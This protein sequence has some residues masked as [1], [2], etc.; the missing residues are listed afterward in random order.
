MTNFSKPQRQSPVGIIVMFADT[1]QKFARAFWPIILISVFRSDTFDK[2][3]VVLSILGFL[4]ISAIVAYLKYLN[5]TFHIDDENNEFVI[6]DGIFNK[7]RTTISLDKIQQVNINQSLIQR[8]IN[9][10]ELNVD[11]AGSTNKEGQIKAVSHEL[12]LALKAQLLENDAKLENANPYAETVADHAEPFIK[13][14][15]LSLLKIGFTSNYLRSFGLIL[16]FFVTIYENFRKLAESETIDPTTIDSYI[17]KETLVKFSLYLVILVISGILII[18]LIRTVVKYFNFEMTKKSG[19]LI[20][21]YGLLNTKSTILRPNRV[22]IAAITRNFFQKK[23]D[24]SSIKIKQAGSG[25][26][27]QKNSVIEIPGCNTAEQNA[28]MDLLYKTIPEKGAMLT[29]NIRKLLF[30]IFL[31]IVLPLGV[32]L[33]AMQKDQQIFQL[34]WIASAYIVIV[35]IILYFSFKNYRLYV[36]D[37]FIIKQS[38]A[39]DITTE[40]IEATKI[41]AISTS[42]LFWHKKLDIGSLVLY[43]AGGKLSFQ[44]GNFTKIKNHVNTW[45][46]EIETSNSNWM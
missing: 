27:K 26:S 1:V 30:S 14:S 39:W 25:D 42:Q 41:Q 45:L 28:I 10:H 32:F 34:I 44:L 35:S 4:V 24:V 37:A 22:Q 46:Y 21:S 43:T 6:S 29:P 13:I 18:N 33:F 9:V 20:L 15:F 2:L 23:L 5:F 36:S 19:S 38:G 31:S 7:S 3:I 40:I 17:N 12:A 8:L 11:S 16:A